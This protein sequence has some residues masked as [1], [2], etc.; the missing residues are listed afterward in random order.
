MLVDR[1]VWEVD[2]GPGGD[3]ERLQPVHHL[4]EEDQG[5]GVV[6]HRVR[7]ALGGGGH[8]L[9]QEFDVFGAALHGAGRQLHR[10]PQL[11]QTFL[12]G[13][14]HGGHRRQIDHTVRPH[15]ARGSGADSRTPQPGRRSRLEVVID[16]RVIR[17]SETRWRQG[18]PPGGGQGGGAVHGLRR[19][20]IIS[21]VD[22]FEDVVYGEKRDDDQMINRRATEGGSGGA[23]GATDAANLPM[24]TELETEGA[25]GVTL[26]S[27]TG[28]L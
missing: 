17:D 25:G 20:I 6:L 5:L 23:G 13:E 22:L 14:F 27:Q 15:G 7:H 21:T 10:R 26:C 2:L 1:G 8:L 12:L 24:R 9:P 19:F 11:I 4:R 28:W 18:P 3:E 16:V